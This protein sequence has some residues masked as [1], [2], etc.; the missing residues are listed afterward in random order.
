MSSTLYIC[1]LLYV[2]S[3]THDDGWKNGPKHGECHSK[4]NKFQA[5]V[6]LV[7]FTIKIY[8]DARLY[9]RQIERA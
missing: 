5:L 6:H 9:E 1:L 4:S 7:R 3:L 8:D 2:Q